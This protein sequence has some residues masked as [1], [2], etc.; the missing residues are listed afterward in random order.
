M[1]NYNPTSEKFITICKPNC[2]KGRQL[3]LRSNRDQVVQ[4]GL[5]R[6]L[7]CVYETNFSVSLY[8]LKKKG[9]HAALRQI[10]N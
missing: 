9:C 10:R 5:K 8:G 4:N 6:I 2:K 1:G 3:L 7:S